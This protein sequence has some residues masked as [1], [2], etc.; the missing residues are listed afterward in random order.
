MVIKCIVY[1]CKS[2]YVTEKN[3]NYVSMF[4]FPLDKADLLQKWQQ[5]INRSN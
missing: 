3:E 1:G 2:G 5:F 4:C